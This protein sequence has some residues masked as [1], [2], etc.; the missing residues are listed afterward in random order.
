MH[1]KNFDLKEGRIHLVLQY[2]HGINYALISD[3]V[4]VA[5]KIPEANIMTVRGDDAVFSIFYLWINNDNDAWLYGPKR[6]FV[7]CRSLRKALSQWN[8]ATSSKECSPF[9]RR[10]RIWRRTSICTSI[11]VQYI[12]I[13]LFHSLQFFSGICLFCVRMFRKWFFAQEFH[14]RLNLYCFISSYYQ[15]LG[16][17]FFFHGSTGCCPL[18]DSRSMFQKK[19]EG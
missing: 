2:T 18:F 4:C 12:D 1:S 6:C 9:A 19:N 16:S 15:D 8:R 10:S 14:N 13:S 5:A 11:S 7:V 3:H 17:S